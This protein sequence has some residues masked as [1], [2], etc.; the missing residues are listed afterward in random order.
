MIKRIEGRDDIKIIIGKGYALGRRRYV[1]HAV[2]INSERSVSID[3]R[4]QAHALRRFRRPLEATSRTAADIE[5]AFTVVKLTRQPE[6]FRIK[7]F[8]VLIVK[9]SFDL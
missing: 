2:P 7:G 9:R 4:I 8:E 6:H 3:Q 5:H 1:P